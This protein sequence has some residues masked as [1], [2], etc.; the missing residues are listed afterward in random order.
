[1]N[2]KIKK[3]KITPDENRCIKTT[4]MTVEKFS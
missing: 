1:M 2:E 3:T 4:L